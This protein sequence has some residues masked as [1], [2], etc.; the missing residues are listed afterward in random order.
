MID[1]RSVATLHRAC[2]H[3]IHQPE[4]RKLDGIVHP[5]PLKRTGQ[6]FKSTR[7]VQR[8]LSPHDQIANVSARRANQ[9]T[10]AKFHSA[11]DQAFTSWAE[12]TGVPMAA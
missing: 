5:K 8:F 4:Q 9:D 3:L 2:L 12:V 10:A 6:R 7:Q 1:G 11:H